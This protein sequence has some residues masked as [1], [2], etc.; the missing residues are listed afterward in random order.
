MKNAIFFV[1]ILSSQFSMAQDV[2]PF[3]FGVKAGSPIIAGFTAEYVL[4]V[5]DNRIG[6]NV[7]IGYFPLAGTD[8]KINYTTLTLGGNFYLNKKGIGRG[9]FVGVAFSNLGF[10]ITWN[11]VT[12]STS[13]TGGKAESTINVPQFQMKAGIKTG[14]GAFYFCPEIGYGIASIPKTASIT[15]TYPDGTKESGSEPIKDVTSD[16]FSLI[17]SITLG[18]SF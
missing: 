8:V 1:L 11:N 14:K 5:L 12:S 10:G 7:D 18:L 15:A 16:S 13:K 3:R 17:L 6:I 9:P 4:P 2:R